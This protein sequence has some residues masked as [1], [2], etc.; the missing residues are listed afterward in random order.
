[1][2]KLT[3]TAVAAK[4]IKR[5]NMLLCLRVFRSESLS[6]LKSGSKL[7]EISDT[8][9]FLTMFMKFSRIGDI[10][11]S[12]HMIQGEELSSSDDKK[13]Q[14]LLKIADI[15]IDKV[16]LEKPGKKEESS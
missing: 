15:I 7:S 13:L 6:T 1:M 8:A 14:F 11:K 9:L 4:P 10:K 16:L 5:Q 3:E 12:E 2:S